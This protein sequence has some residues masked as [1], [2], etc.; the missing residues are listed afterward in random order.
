MVDRPVSDD[1]ECVTQHANMSL[2]V[3]EGSFPQGNTPGH[4]PLD[5]PVIHMSRATEA[6]REFIKDSKAEYLMSD[7]YSGYSR[8]TQGTKIKN[9]FCMAHA[10]RKFV[11]AEPNYPEA[12]PF[13]DLIGELYQLEREMKDRSPPEKK[14]IRQ[15]KSRPILDKIQTQLFAL[16]VLAQGLRMPL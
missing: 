2:I 11:E 15:E 14:Q 16:Q 12:L 8:V 3:P 1:T 7:A 6:A 4:F 5:R 10:R 9:A 13:V